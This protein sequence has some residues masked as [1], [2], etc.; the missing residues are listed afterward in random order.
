MNHGEG[1]GVLEV[2]DESL[3]WGLGRRGWGVE[4]RGILIYQPELMWP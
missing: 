1:T 4:S 3:G 2:V